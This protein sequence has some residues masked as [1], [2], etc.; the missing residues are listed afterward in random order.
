MSELALT[1]DN[2]IVRHHDPEAEVAWAS[3]CA[4]ALVRVIDSQPS[5][6]V[7]IG[8]GDY[9]K[10]EGWQVLGAMTKVDS[11]RVE[12]TREYR[13]P[14]TGDA[15]G[16]EA[17]V[18]VADRDGNVRGEGEASCL[19]TEAN[20]KQRDDFALRSM[21]QTRAMG[22]AYR[23]AL[24]YIVGLA[25]YQTTPAEEMPEPATKNSPKPSTKKISDAQRK[26]LF[27][28]ASEHGVLDDRVKEIVLLTGGVEST[29]DLTV[30]RYDLVIDMLERQDGPPFA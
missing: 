5:M 12:W 22:K 4:K 2:E 29:K 13:D 24:S 15:I 8:K 25:G 28:I 16:W 1:A 6:K 27:A 9:I 19:R 18:Q 17:R 14:A 11:V 20:W 21:A 10:V 26:R 7:K 23:M 30:E 3:E